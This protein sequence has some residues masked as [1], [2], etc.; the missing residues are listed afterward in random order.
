MP[1]PPISRPEAMME[2]QPKEQ[3]GFRQRLVFQSSLAPRSEDDPS[4][5]ALYVD[6]AAYLPSRDHFHTKAIRL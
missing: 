2:R 4:K 3:L 1:L 6:D 5:K